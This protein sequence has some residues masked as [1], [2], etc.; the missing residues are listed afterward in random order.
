MPAT[1]T[2][3]RCLLPPG[4]A[5]V[6]AGLLSKRATVDSSPRA[7]PIQTSHHR[8]T[9]RQSRNQTAQQKLVQDATNLA[10]SSTEAL[11]TE[12]E[13]AFLCASLSLWLMQSIFRGFSRRERHSVGPAGPELGHDHARFPAGGSRSDRDRSRTARTRRPEIG[14]PAVAHPT[15]RIFVDCAEQSSACQPAAELCSAQST[16]REPPLRSQPTAE[17]CSAQSTKYEVRSPES[18]DGKA[19]GADN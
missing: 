13:G 7:P 16:R 1:A 4:A 3:R 9:A 15:G 17:L 11:R 14:N 8:D 12:R 5:P 10:V 6:A 2:G 18:E 19:D